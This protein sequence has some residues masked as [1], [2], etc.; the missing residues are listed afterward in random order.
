M[1]PKELEE[2]KEKAMKTIINDMHKTIP[3]DFWVSYKAASII[4]MNELIIEIIKN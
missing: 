4:A 1:T 2:V 3:K